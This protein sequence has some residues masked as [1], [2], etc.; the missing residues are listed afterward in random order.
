MSPQPTLRNTRAALFSAVCVT[1][2]ASGHGLA[3]HSVPAA[4]TIGV[5]FAGVLT[6]AWTLAGTERS[7]ATILGGLLGGQFALH[8]LFTAGS[9]HV[10]GVA[11][12]P[13]GISHG[14]TGMTAAHVAAAVVSAWWLRR[15]ERTAWA[16]ARRAVALVLPVRLVPAILEL[17]GL[18]PPRPRSVPRPRRSPLLHSVVRRG[19]PLHACS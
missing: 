2:A 10:H 11:F 3:A 1:L 17:R 18:V 15:G 9:A 7:L 13:A 19:P 8:S 6:V 4:W 16:L 14:G 12:H 5:A